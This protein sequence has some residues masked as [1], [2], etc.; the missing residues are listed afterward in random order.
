MPLGNLELEKKVKQ[1]SK[2]YMK[3][4]YCFYKKFKQKWK[5]YQ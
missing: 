1:I 3:K 2:K 5:F 4:V